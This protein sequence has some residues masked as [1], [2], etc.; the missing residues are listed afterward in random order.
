MSNE[1]PILCID[2][3]HLK[4]EVLAGSMGV[5]T[6]F[7]TMYL[8]WN[9]WQIVRKKAD[10][11]WDPTCIRRS[12]FPYWRSVLQARFPLKVY[13]AYASAD[14]RSGL[15]PGQLGV[16]LSS[17]LMENGSTPTPNHKRCPV[18]RISPLRRNNQP[19]RCFTTA[20]TG[21]FRLLKVLK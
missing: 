12:F 6:L 4:R 9:M 21:A 19:R 11:G 2:I 16:I 20:A 8:Q 1:T 15:K 5:L 7:F 3:I 13:P 18:R 14:P 10:G 17:K